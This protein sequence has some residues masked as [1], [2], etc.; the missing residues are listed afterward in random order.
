[1]KKIIRICMALMLVLGIS[2]CG[3]SKSNQEIVTTL[4]EPVTI[5]F[6]HGLSGQLETE[7]QTLTQEFNDQQP[8]I[9][10]N[11]VNQG[12]YGDL[13]KKMMTASSSNSLPALAM[14]YPGFAFELA[15]QGKVVDLNA[16]IENETVGL[17]KNQYFEPFIKEGELDGA[18]YTLPF[19]KST[20]ILYYNET[21][22]NKL[23]QS[24][25]TTWEEAFSVAKAFTQAT[26]KPGLGIDSPQSFFVTI[27]KDA[28]VNNWKNEDGTFNFAEPKV[29]EIM[30]EFQKGKEEGW[31]RLAGED[32]Y[33]STPFGNGDV[34]MYLGS[35]AG[36]SF[37][38]ASV[39]GKFEWST[40]PYPNKN[41]IQQG[42]SI[43]ALNTVSPQ[44]QFA[45]YEYMKFMTSTP[46]T[47]KWAEATGYLPVTKEGMESSSY[48]QYLSN[49][50]RAK[51][52][53]EQR[54]KM[55][56][57]V[58]TFPGSSEISGT[59]MPEAVTAIIDGGANVEQTLQELNTK[60]EQ[61]YQDAEM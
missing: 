2:A 8:N 31:L 9:T 4:E 23:N 50:P 53:Y 1:M 34:L 16:Y 18:Q 61:A 10:V 47:T 29:V 11:L 58:E 17:D 49:N 56:L 36:M 26:G 12:N 25:P 30:T 13:N 6:W 60:S 38:D 5:E 33:L 37:V 39:D 41:V 7:L 19:N 45:A 28:G 20:E 52:A 15:K 27:L 55:Q 57:L 48:Q 3:S 21:E 43:Y 59:L 22:L 24:I 32:K 44:E 46:I 35:N 14:G 40:A 51:A 42:P 54:D